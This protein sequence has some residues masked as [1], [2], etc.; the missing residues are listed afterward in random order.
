MSNFGFS[1]LRV[2][3]AYEVAYQEARSAVKASAVLAASKQFDTLHD[4][5]ADCSLVVGTASP[6]NRMLRHTLRR[7]E[8]AGPLIRSALE[9]GPVALVFGSEKF[10]MSNDEM[11]RCH[12]LTHIPTRA[13]HESM[14]LGQAVAVCLYE[15]VRADVTALTPSKPRGVAPEVDI[16]RVESLLLETM[17]EC[18]YMNPVTRT[19]TEHKLRRMLHRLQLTAPDVRILLGLLRQILWRFQRGGPAGG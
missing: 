3:N 11:S 1:H 19:S 8:V 16:G 17:Q 13:E 4:A 5:V 15:L 18:G 14:N 9:S 12:W 2:V 10:G 6:G 7:L